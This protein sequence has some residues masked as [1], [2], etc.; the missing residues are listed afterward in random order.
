[1]KNTLFH[2]DNVSV[3]YTTAQQRI[4]AV[5]NVSLQGNRGETIGIVGES[6]SGKSSLANALLMLEPIHTGSMYFEGQNLSKLRPSE[7]RQLRRHIQPIFQDPSASLNQRRS[8]GWHLNEVFL[9]HFPKISQEEQEARI[10]DVLKKVELDPDIRT[11]Y[12]FE[13]SG[14]Q[15]QRLVIARAL[16]LSPKLMILDEPLS[17]LDAALRKSVLS[18]LKELQKIH[19]MGYLFITHDLSTLSAIATHVAVMYRGVIVETAPV[20]ELYQNPIHPYTISLLSCIPIPDPEK[21]KRRI[22]LFFPAQC[23]PPSITEGCCF[24]HRC[25]LATTLCHTEVPPLVTL[26]SQHSVTCHRPSDVTMLTTEPSK[27]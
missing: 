11:R 14:G 21:E 8:I 16:L 5:H 25:P 1:M 2:L 13:L 17:S 6:G 27:Q 12:P 22:S 19:T 26:S 20:D 7:I 23:L 4:R 24:A 3:E 18:L 10:L 9:A 15:K